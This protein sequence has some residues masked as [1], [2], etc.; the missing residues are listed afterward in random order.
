MLREASAEPP[1][2]A[3]VTPGDSGQPGYPSLSKRMLSTAMLPTTRSL[4]VGREI[5][6]NWAPGLTGTQGLG[7]GTQTQVRSRDSNENPKRTRA[8]GRQAC[9]CPS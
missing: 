8:A 2:H 6:S 7:L 5:D 4:R 1:E 3:G 9:L